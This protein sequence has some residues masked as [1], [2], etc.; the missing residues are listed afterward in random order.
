MAGTFPDVSRT[1]VVLPALSL[2]VVD[3]ICFWS[4]HV[5]LPLLL[6]HDGIML[7][8]RRRGLVTAEMVLLTLVIGYGSVLF[9][10]VELGEN[11][12]FRLSIEPEIIAL[13][14]ATLAAAAS[15]VRRAAAHLRPAGLGPSI[16]R[17]H[18]AA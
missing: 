8:L 18:D 13:S 9:N 16:P 17:P 1:P 2:D 7:A 10:A 5:L 3:V 12:R 11:M 14:A 4:L 6:L 15:L